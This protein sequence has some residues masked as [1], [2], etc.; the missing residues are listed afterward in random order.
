MQLLATCHTEVRGTTRCGQ[1]T[2]RGDIARLIHHEDNVRSFGH[3]RPSLL[4]QFAFNLFKEKPPGNWASCVVNT[5]RSATCRGSRA[6]SGK[7][8]VEPATP[9]WAASVRWAGRSRA[10]KGVPMSGL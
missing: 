4:A 1:V 3:G 5:R 7:H 8:A 9:M 6:G 2:G 10:R